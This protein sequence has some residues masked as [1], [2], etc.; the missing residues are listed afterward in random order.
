MN[1][2]LYHGAFA[3][4]L[5]SVAWVGASYFPGN[6]L[7]LALVGVIAVFFLMGAWELQQFQRATA[8]LRSLVAATSD[9]PASLSAWLSPLH[10]SLHNAVRLRTEGERVALPGPALTPYLSGLLVLLGMLGTFLGMVVTLN[11]TGI[12]LQNAVDAA[13]I[14]ASL[15]APVK[16]LGLAFGTSVAGVAASA[17]LGLMSALARRE[18]QRTA[19]QLDACIATTL[20]GF[21]QVHQREESLRLLRSQADAMPAVVAQLQ[22]LVAQ[23]TRQG[24]TLQD[25]LVGSQQQ[26]HAEAQRAYTGLAES[27]DRSLKASLADSARVASAAIEPA[28]QATMAGL[29]REATTVRDTLGAV[30][31][32]HLDGISTRLEASTAALAERWQSAVAEQQRHNAAA[33][34]SLRAG[35]DQFAATF[36]QRASALVDGVGARL[37]DSSAQW[38]DAWGGA[39]AAQREGHEALMAHTRDVLASAVG[40]F[41]S[42]ASALRQSVADAHAAWDKAAGEREQAR[43]DVFHGGLANVTQTLQRQGEQDAAAAAERQQQICTTLERTAQAITTQ[44]ESQARAT[45]AE[46]AQL[47]QAAA[48]APRAATQVIGELRQA[49]SDSLVR[50]NAAL[51]ERNRLLA[52]L[53]GL[54]DAV[55]H[56]S[57]EQRAAIDT[58]VSTTTDVLDRV[59]SRFADAVE[60]ESRSLQAV[61]AQVATGAAEV[62][63]LGEGFGL[64]V[65][66]FSQTSEQLAAQLQRIEAALGQSMARSDEQLAY[67]VAQ[68]REI[69]DLTL[70]SQK[71]IVDDLQRLAKAPEEAA[72]A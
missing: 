14:R 11:G 53:A 34:E 62:A 33:A 52:T 31:Q 23:V 43:M 26:F 56:A 69:V 72:A 58:L 20:R 38:T 54:L 19:Q 36:E 42:H 46:I 4:G 10:P 57:T 64:A 6:L 8:G 30:V 24:E 16:G 21:S 60:T 71:Q 2:S 66:L 18:R 50:D 55:N 5:L 68:A 39:L 22:Q 63:S 15:V 51:D 41:E 25:R 37:S 61:S 49:L 1:R 27:V 17:M 67:Y 45:L 32:Q 3:V 7:A 35:L 9:A 28:V 40:G 47:M 65:Q 48:E 29:A 59:G 12:A 44:A 70:G 13:A